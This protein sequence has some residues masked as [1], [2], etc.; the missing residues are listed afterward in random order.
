LATA[1]P[2]SNG[3]DEKRIS[4]CGHGT[5]VSLLTVRVV[6]P[7]TS[8]CQGDRLLGKR[9]SAVGAG[10]GIDAG[11]SD[12]EALDGPPVHQVL[13]NN[14][15][16][17]F[18]LDPAVPHGLR[19]D[20]DGGTVLALVKAQG[21]VHADAGE[22]GGL[23]ELLYLGENFALSIGG[24][25]GAGSALGAYVMTDEDVMVVKGQW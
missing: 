12:A 11:I 4:G 9:L 16:R 7:R 5:M 20:H 8:I 3:F 13:L 23:G 15:G 17:V 24:T 25:R 22:A 2:D 18:R 19:V 14:F 1:G 21:L 6:T 10:L